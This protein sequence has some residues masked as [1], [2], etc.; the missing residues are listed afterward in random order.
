MRASWA[1]LL[2]GLLI[3]L[4]LAFSTR[5][6]IVNASGSNMQAWRIDRWTGS[7]SYCMKYSDYSAC[8][9]VREPSAK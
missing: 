1:I 5:Y 4:G 3:S 9:P 8:T 2:A 7:V 6:E